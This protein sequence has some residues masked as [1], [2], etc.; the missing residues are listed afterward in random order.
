MT[1]DVPLDFFVLFSSTTGLL[2]SSM[3]GHYAAANTSSPCSPLQAQG[4][5]PAVAV[6]QGVWE[7]M[8]DSGYQ[9][10]VTQGSLFRWPPR[11]LEAFGLPS[12]R[13][14]A[15]HD[16]ERRLT[17]LKSVYEAGA[18]DRSAN[19]S[20]RGRPRPARTNREP[21]CCPDSKRPTDRA[22]QFAHGL[23]QARRLTEFARPR[24]TSTS[25]AGCSTR[26]GFAD[27]G[28]SENQAGRGIGRGS[29]TLAFNHPTVGALVAYIEKQLPQL[30]EAVDPVQRVE[31]I[32]QVDEDDDLSEDELAALLADK[33]ARVQ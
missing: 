21:V 19:C 4:Q 6:S 33:L 9:A 18:D 23:R 24:R 8:R 29:S 14:D 17:M 25:I 12:A 26:H 32:S 27:V 13:V 1:R 10:R 3:L 16:R 20:D 5:L 11:A 22:P 15:D 2:G 31:P 28:R 7:E 30:F